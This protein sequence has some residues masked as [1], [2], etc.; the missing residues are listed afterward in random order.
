[1]RYFLG[2]LLLVVVATSGHR[3]WER[4]T[5]PGDLRLHVHAGE[6]QVV[7]IGTLGAPEGT[8]VHFELAPV[9]P[10]AGVEPIRGTVTVRQGEIALQRFLPAAGPW[11]LRMHASSDG[12]K[13]E[14]VQVVKGDCPTVGFDPVK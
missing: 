10:A 7:A 14:A 3:A 13:W 9:E 6:R 5:D 2:F 1:M 11:R 12:R 4:F 8:P